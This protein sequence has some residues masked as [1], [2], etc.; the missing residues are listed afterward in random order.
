M[1]VNLVQIV[2]DRS[3]LRPNE[4]VAVMTCHWRGAVVG[5]PDD[6]ADM[7]A[8]RRANARDKIVTFLNAIKP[9]CNTRIKWRHLYWYEAGLP[10]GTPSPRI[11]EHSIT[12]D[13]TGSAPIPPQISC[14]VTFRTAVRKNWGRFYIP[15]MALSTLGP[16]G[17][18]T[19][20]T[21]DAICVA[22]AVLTNR[23]GSQTE[24]LTVWSPTEGTH[25]DPQQVEVDDVPDVIRSRRFSSTLYKKIVAAG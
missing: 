20:A 16:N 13:G 14:S 8:G 19:N 7:D 10:P 2:A 18:Y 4:D 9:Y 22:A 21:V 23:G 6:L 25:H 11:D 17:E 3:T 1:S 5:L 24:T 12:V 15:G